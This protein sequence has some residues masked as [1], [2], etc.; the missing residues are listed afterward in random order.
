MRN[1]EGGNNGQG[2]KNRHE[3]GWDSKKD[4]R[5]RWID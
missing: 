2:V 1:E 4:E 3:Q 5:R